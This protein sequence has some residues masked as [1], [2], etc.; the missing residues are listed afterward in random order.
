MPDHYS[1]SLSMI[2]A[3]ILFWILAFANNFVISLISL[4]FFQIHKLLLAIF[5]EREAGQCCSYYLVFGLLTYSIQENTMSHYFIWPEFERTM[6]F[7]VW[8]QLVN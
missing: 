6:Y 8:T 2:T 1:A 4:T 5:L 7:Q 3:I